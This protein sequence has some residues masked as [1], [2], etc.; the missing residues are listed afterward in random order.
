MFWTWAQHR[1]YACLVQYESF[2][3]FNLFFG[4]TLS[5][6]VYLFYLLLFLFWVVR[7]GPYQ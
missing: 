6:H 5:N 3:V 4:D 2:L 1:Y 7:C